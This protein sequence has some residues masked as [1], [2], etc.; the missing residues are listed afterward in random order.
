[1]FSYYHCLRETN[2]GMLFYPKGKMNVELENQIW[3]FVSY[4][5]LVHPSNNSSS[6]FSITSGATLVVLTVLSFTNCV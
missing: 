3:R 1:M 4:D 5:T 6:I 2:K